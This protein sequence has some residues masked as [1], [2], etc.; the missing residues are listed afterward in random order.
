MHE[1]HGENVR[2][3]RTN[4]FAKRAILKNRTQSQGGSGSDFE[5]RIKENECQQCRSRHGTRIDCLFTT[6]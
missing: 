6:G 4:P 1:M 3:E 2:F 5:R